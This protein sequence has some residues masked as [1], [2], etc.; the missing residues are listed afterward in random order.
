MG[1]LTNILANRLE[2]FAQDDYKRAFYD[3]FGMY[4]SE[5]ACSAIRSGFSVIHKADSDFSANIRNLSSVIAEY[6][7]Y[8]GHSEQKIYFG[9]GYLMQACT[10]PEGQVLSS[11]EWAVHVIAA[12]IRNRCP[13][14][15]VSGY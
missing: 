11:R 12:E 13:S 4:P 10:T 8:V 5:S 1:I 6:A 9:L 2:K 3:R 14:F 15:S 7:Q